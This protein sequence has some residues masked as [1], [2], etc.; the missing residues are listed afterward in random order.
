MI[1]VMLNICVLICHC[2]R[3]NKV[4]STQLFLYMFQEIIRPVYK[5]HNEETYVGCTASNITFP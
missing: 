3:T 4:E 1:F 2:Y 5:G